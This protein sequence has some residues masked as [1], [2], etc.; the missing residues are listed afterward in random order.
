[1]ERDRKKERERDIYQKKE[2]LTG[3]RETDKE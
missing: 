3:E 1:L 2:N